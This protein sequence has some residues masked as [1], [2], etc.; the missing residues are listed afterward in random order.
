[1]PS[2]VWGCVPQPQP[3]LL[4]WTLPL[5]KEEHSLGQ[6]RGSR[7]NIQLRGWMWG[8]QGVKGE[9]L[10]GFLAQASEIGPTWLSLQDPPAL[11]DTH[12]L[13]CQAYAPVHAGLSG[14]LIAAL[15]QPRPGRKR[16]VPRP[17]WGACSR[18]GRGSPG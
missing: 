9:G 12:R 6:E 13:L 11:P 4:A 18:Q 7:A 10:T 5:P 8:D 2:S 16:Q 17:P 15:V 1:M 14:S 3:H